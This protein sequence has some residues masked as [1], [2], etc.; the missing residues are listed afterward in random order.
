MKVNPTGVEIITTDT[1]E[2]IQRYTGKFDSRPKLGCFCPTR[3]HLSVSSGSCVITYV[4]SC[5]GWISEPDSNLFIYRMLTAAIQYRWYLH[6][7]LGARSKRNFRFV[8]RSGTRKMQRSCLA[9]TQIIGCIG[10]TCPL[11]NFNHRNN[12]S[13]QK[14]GANAVLFNH[15]VVPTRKNCREGSTK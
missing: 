11:M 6:A 9:F 3:Y 1:H 4:S 10:G 2:T 7:Y 14:R 5:C 12:S 8:T 13:T 15:H